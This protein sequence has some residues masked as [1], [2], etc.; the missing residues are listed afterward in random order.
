M[1]PSMEFLQKISS[2]TLHYATQCEIQVKIVCSTQRNAV[3]TTHIRKYLGE[4][5]T[6]FENILG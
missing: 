5:E 6:K 4:I 1:R 2:T 3:L